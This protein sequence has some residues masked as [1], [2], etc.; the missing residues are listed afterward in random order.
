M[1]RSFPQNRVSNKRKTCLAAVVG[2]D[3]SWRKKR[4]DLFEN[5]TLWD[6]DSISTIAWGNRVP[7]TTEKNPQYGKG[8]NPVKLQPL[9]FEHQACYGVPPSIKMFPVPFPLCLSFHLGGRAS[10]CLSSSWPQR[11]GCQRRVM[12]ITMVVLWCIHFLPAVTTREEPLAERVSASFK[13][14]ICSYLS[15]HT[16]REAISL[17]SDAGICLL[18]LFVLEGLWFRRLESESLRMKMSSCILRRKEVAVCSL[19]CQH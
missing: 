19:R 16:T 2:R 15:V 10:L 8:R 4:P 9:A 12:A 13:L 14:Y 5:R 7:L 1:Q 3:G 18:V 11:W 17:S 6:P